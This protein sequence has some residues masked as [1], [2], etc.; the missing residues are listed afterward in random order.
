[1]AN[2]LLSSAL[3][4]FRLV[5]FAEGISY[6]L[7]LGIAM[8]LKYVW[9]IPQAVQVIGMIHGVLFVTYCILLLMAMLEMK[10]KFI[11]GLMLFIISLFPFGFLFAENKFLKKQTKNNA[12]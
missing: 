10:W 12:A 11:Y 5:S 7:L 8:P 4:R 6:L 3:G 2:S 9:N 1:M